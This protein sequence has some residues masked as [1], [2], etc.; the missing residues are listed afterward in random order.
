MYAHK[1]Q[2]CEELPAGGMLQSGLL[3]FLCCT[4]RGN[5]H[6]VTG[7]G[8]SAQ[9]IPKSHASCTCMSWMDNPKRLEHIELEMS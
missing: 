1:A 4:C 5:F 3:V 7:G 8:S 6:K 9:Q 2:P